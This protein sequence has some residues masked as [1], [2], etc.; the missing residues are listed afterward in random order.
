MRARLLVGILLSTS[1]MWCA[2]FTGQEQEGAQ[3]DEHD[4]A[5][6]PTVD[7]TSDAGSEAST[8][9]ETDAGVEL[10]PRHLRVFVTEK[11]YESTTLGNNGDGTCRAEAQLHLGLDSAAAN[12]FVAY[13]R[14]SSS[15]SPSHADGP[16]QNAQHL[17][18][19]GLGWYDVE[20]N[21]VFTE[22]PSDPLARIQI[23]ILLA[24]R[25]SPSA[26]TVVWTGYGPYPDTYSCTQSSL[27]FTSKEHWSFVGSPADT[28]IGKSGKWIWRTRDTLFKCESKAHI[29]CFETLPPP[30][31]DGGGCDAGP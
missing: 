13:R 5:E 2:A 28:G 20:G 1:V 30:D 17:F 26:E 9:A 22:P 3:K 25:T 11:A 24:N 16:D 19:N 4:A 12:A 8:D 18:G 14:R 29:Y 6:K 31:C 23:P 27:P 15:D 7:A 10:P 21:Q